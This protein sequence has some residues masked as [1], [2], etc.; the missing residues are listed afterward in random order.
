MAKRDMMNEKFP[1]IPD[2]LN[3][4]YGSDERGVPRRWIKMRKEAIKCVGPNFSARRI[5]KK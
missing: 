5:V 4:F 1:N 2:S 3:L